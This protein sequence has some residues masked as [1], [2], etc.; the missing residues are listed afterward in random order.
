MKS[1]KFKYY[2]GDY[3]VEVMDLIYI[4]LNE[5]YDYT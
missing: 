2:F 3:Y 1:I 4:F 5:Y